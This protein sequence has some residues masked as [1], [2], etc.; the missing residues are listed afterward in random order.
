[1]NMDSYADERTTLAAAR[2]ALRWTHRGIIEAATVAT[3]TVDEAVQEWRTLRRNTG[4]C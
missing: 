1:M 4:R 3:I 2:E